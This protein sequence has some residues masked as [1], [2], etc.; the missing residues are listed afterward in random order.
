MA[1]L[2][3]AFAATLW[4][5]GYALEIASPDL[6]TKLFWAK[7]EYLGI[8]VIPLAWLIFSAQYSGNTGWLERSPVRHIL[9]W[10][11]PV[12]TLCL[13]WTNEQHHLVWQQAGLVPLADITILSI[14]HGPWF[15]VL[16]FFSYCLLLAG[17]IWLASAM[18]RSKTE[19][20][21]TIGFVLAGILIPWIAN[22][23]YLADL[24]PIPNLDWT[25]FAF[26]LAGVM[27]FLSLFRFHL[28]NI[29]PIAY[30]NVFDGLA[31]AALVL[32]THDCIV[33]LNPAAR[34]MIG[35]RDPT[36]LGQPFAQLLPE[37]AV[38][39]DGLA[40]AGELQ[41]EI[42]HGNEPDRRF[43]QLQVAP[44]SSQR[45]TPIGRLVTLRD[46]TQRKREQ[47]ELEQI[48]DELEK[49]VVE[50]TAAL[51]QTNRRLQAELAQRALAEQALRESEYT[52]RVLFENASDAILLFDLEGIL[53]KVNP[54]AA[55][56]LGYTPEELVGM[57]IRDI[58]IPE[59]YTSTQE[60]KFGLLSG[61]TFSPY[62]RKYRNKA[63][64]VIPLEITVAVVPD[65]D[66]RPRLIQSIGRDITERKKAEQEQHQ[67]LK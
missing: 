4:S 33:D 38:P 21:R 13:V 30:K 23:L 12:L 17:S 53:R 44:L 49:H 62:E 64:E 40:H 5:V 16:L 47:A 45:G 11:I 24:N 39:I 43:C 2:V 3:L 52:Y 19:N 46:I 63:G 57:T 1:L 18:I 67:L 10:I 50:Q 32:D 27:F 15:W 9:L 20:R 54:K 14:E 60:R 25:P 41:V 65:A 42:P 34:Q 35:D 56:V 66:G 31:D 22:F 6:P 37:F 29:K 26:I 48:R 58:V 7:I 28:L 61:E 51:E 36:P 8:I 55:S 59:E